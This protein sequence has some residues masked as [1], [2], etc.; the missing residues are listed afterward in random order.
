MKVVNGKVVYEIKECDS[1]Y[2][3]GYSVET[4]KD[5]PNKNQKMHGKKCIFCG[6]KSKEHKLLP[7]KNN[8]YKTCYWCKGT[9]FILENKLSWM[10]REVWNQIKIVK[11]VSKANA[12]TTFNEG[13]LGIGVVAGCTDYGRH[14]TEFPNDDDLIKHVI[15]DKTFLGQVCNIIDEEDNIMDMVLFRKSDGYHVYKIANKQEV[16]V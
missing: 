12:N 4:L 6:T 3:T 5:C 1:C 11:V 7:R 14:W 2:G 10:P 9:G 13:Y 8:K 16:A 15:A